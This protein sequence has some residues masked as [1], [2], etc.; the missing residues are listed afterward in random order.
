MSLKILKSDT[1]EIIV[2]N[3]VYI[4]FA[5]VSG[6]QKYD[7]TSDTAYNTIQT[8]FLKPISNFALYPA[9]KKRKIK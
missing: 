4:G 3:V 7:I 5:T 9:N 1:V 8:H 2:D 6:K